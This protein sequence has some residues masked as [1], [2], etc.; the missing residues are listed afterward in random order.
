MKVADS[1]SI[2]LNNPGRGF[3]ASMQLLPLLAIVLM[4]TGCP[5]IQQAYNTENQTGGTVHV[6]GTGF[7]PG[8]Q[9]VFYA[10]HTPGHPDSWRIYE[11]QASPSGTVEVN[12]GYTWPVG[13]PE[14]QDGLPGCVNGSNASPVTV[15]I[16]ALDRESSAAPTKTVNLKNC[17]TAWS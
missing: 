9:V 5:S 11:T 14:V 2:F 6:S 15:I 10:R 12:I 7:T 3:R 17:G 16:T 1:L 13:D 4:L 8:G